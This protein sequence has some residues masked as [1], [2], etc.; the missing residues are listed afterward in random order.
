MASG[1]LA[2][3]EP[4]DHSE[5]GDLEHF[6]LILQDHL[7]QALGKPIQEAS[8]SQWSPN[9]KDEVPHFFQSIYINQP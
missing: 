4:T 7:S 6:F 3:Q 9:S 5:L 1:M 2:E 8:L